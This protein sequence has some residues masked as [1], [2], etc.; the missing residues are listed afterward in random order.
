MVRQVVT[1]FQSNNVL[2]NF[3]SLPQKAPATMW[4]SQE[5]I[6]TVAMGHRFNSEW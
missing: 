6:S 5:V 2:E 1:N 4:H 3:S